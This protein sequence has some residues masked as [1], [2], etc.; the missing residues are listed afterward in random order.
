MTY[1]HFSKSLQGSKWATTM[2]PISIE[3]TL[4]LFLLIHNFLLIG[5]VTALHLV[6][7]FFKKKQQ[8]QSFTFFVQIPNYFCQKLDISRPSFWPLTQGQ[9]NSC[10]MRS[11]CDHHFY[12]KADRNFSWIFGSKGRLNVDVLN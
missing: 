8:Q 4:F 12:P 2:R 3:S 10:S 1:M 7:P 9:S 5:Y 6:L 11:K